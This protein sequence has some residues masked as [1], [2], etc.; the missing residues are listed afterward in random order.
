M[1]EGGSGVHLDINRVLGSQRGSDLFVRAHAIVH[2]KNAAIASALAEGIALWALKADVTRGKHT[3]TQLVRHQLQ[4]GK[5][6][7]TRDES[8]V[9]DRLCQKIIS[10]GL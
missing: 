6:T 1:K 4:P 10:T 5:R 9:R 2:H 8:H 7:H 3:H